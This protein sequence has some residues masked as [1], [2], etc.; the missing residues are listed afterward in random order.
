MNKKVYYPNLERE[1]AGRG[2]KKKAIAENINVCTKTLRNKMSGKV[3]FT[4]PEVSKI[5]CCFFPDMTPDTLFK[6]HDE[7]YHQS[8]R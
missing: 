2:I 6:T 4:W 8:A 3:P 7:I 1:I 5:R